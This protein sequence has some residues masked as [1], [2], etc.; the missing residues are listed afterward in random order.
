MKKN[1][2]EI[3][4]TNATKIKVQTIRYKKW[5]WKPVMQSKKMRWT[6]ISNKCN[7]I[8]FDD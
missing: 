1:D 6:N 4:I 7:Q 8:M 5:N 3:A 2:E